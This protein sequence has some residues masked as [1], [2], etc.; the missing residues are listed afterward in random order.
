[1]EKTVIF[2]FKG[3]P[4]CFVHVLLNSLDIKARGGHCRIVLEGEACGLVKELHQ[5]SHPLH[6]LYSQ[7]KEKGLIAGVC[8]ACAIKFAALAA[9]EE[10][11]LQ[12]LDEMNGHAAMAPFLAE[13]YEIITL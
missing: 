13:G 9:A 4:V 8:R 2:A 10:Q 12:L 7:V 6:Q 1:M 11:G 5:P 3:N